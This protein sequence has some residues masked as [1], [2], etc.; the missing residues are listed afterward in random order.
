MNKKINWI[1]TDIKG[2]H[3]HDVLLR[4]YVADPAAFQASNSVQDLIFLWEQLV[5]SVMEQIHI[6]EFVL[7]PH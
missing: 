7:L 2:Q 4:L 6:S 1:K 5:Y 3:I